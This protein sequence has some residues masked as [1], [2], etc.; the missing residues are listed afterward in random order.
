MRIRTAEAADAAAISQIYE[1]YARETAITFAEHAPTATEYAARMADARYPFVVAEEAGAVCGFAYASAFREKE[2]YRWD[3]ELTVYL[4]P[5]LEG[6][7]TGRALLTECLD[8][9]RRLGYLNAYSCITLPNERSVG[10]HRR[11]GFRELGIFP[12]TGYKL[13]RWHDVVWMG[14]ALGSFDGVPG[15]PGR[16]SA[17]AN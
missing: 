3:A 13:G 1:Y 11:L 8:R 2:A 6:R 15:E 9:L 7:G 10:L 12:R 5:G 16:P 17:A 14:L 4:A